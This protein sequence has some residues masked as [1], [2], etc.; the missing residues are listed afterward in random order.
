MVA[1]MSAISDIHDALDNVEAADTVLDEL[2]A[3][4]TLQALVVKHTRASYA[5]A[6]AAHRTV[7][8]AA[9][10]GVSRQAIA[11]RARQ[12]GLTNPPTGE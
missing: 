9:H 11:K 10:L 5:A 4:I 7:E 2:S 6:L 3:M 8:I 12:L 1:A